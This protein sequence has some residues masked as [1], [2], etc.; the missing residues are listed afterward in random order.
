VT[1]LANGL[2]P[3]RRAE[4]GARL[5]A[6]AGDDLVPHDE[7]WAGYQRRRMSRRLQA[8]LVPLPL[9]WARRIRMTTAADAM[10]DA[11]TALHDRAAGL[12]GRPGTGRLV[13][14]L[15]GLSDELSDEAD[16]LQADVGTRVGGTVPRRWRG[17]PVDVSPFPPPLSNVAGVRRWVREWQ[18]REGRAGPRS[19]RE[20]AIAVTGSAE[21]QAIRDAPE[22]PS[23][24]MAEDVARGTRRHIVQRGRGKQLQDR[25]GQLP[26]HTEGDGR[27]PHLK[28][29][30]DRRRTAR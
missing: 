14:E 6:A 18:V 13:D 27:M 21:R 15:M 8:G 1:Y 22:P 23:A 4:I 11:A 30:S 16:R 12:L 28:E 2:D 5:I 17:D 10:K 24:R 20:R 19:T 3:D 29:P 7:A 26:D 25:T 9:A